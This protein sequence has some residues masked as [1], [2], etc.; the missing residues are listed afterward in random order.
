VLPVYQLLKPFVTRCGS[1][2]K[3]ITEAAISSRHI[4]LKDL[5]TARS[6]TAKGVLAD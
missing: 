5:A 1:K 4:G 3:I 2:L 6:I